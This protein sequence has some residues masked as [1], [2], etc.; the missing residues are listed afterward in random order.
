MTAGRDET[1]RR[2]V[3]GGASVFADS[4]LVDAENTTIAASLAMSGSSAKNGGY[5]GALVFNVVDNSTTAQ[6]EVQGPWN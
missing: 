5:N 3:R 4:L 1:R 6:I 2:G